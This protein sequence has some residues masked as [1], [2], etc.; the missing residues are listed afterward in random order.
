MGAL[1]ER[2]YVWNFFISGHHMG[3]IPLK[4]AISLWEK[5]ADTGQLSLRV[6]K[7]P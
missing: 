3:D 7:K 5:E 6:I 1:V 2:R 4:R